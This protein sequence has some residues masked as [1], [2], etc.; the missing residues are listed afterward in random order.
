MEEHFLKMYSEY[1]GTDFW[2]SWGF[3]WP[4]HRANNMCLSKQ[5]SFTEVTTP[6][7]E[8]LGIIWSSLASLQAMCKAV[9]LNKS[10]GV[11]GNVCSL[12]SGTDR[13][14]K[15]IAPNDPL[16]LCPSWKYLCK[17]TTT[18]FPQGQLNHSCVLES[19]RISIHKHLSTMIYYL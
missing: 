8:K 13:L 3:L 2:H 9:L 15:Q 1:F 5:C 4:K 19:C 12:C 16:L 7:K 6:Y 11:V 10:L 17:R 14:A 18:C